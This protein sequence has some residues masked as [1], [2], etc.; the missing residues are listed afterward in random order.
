MTA[1]GFLFASIGIVAV[2]AGIGLSNPAVL[3]IGAP[4]LVLLAV[5]LA[6]QRTAAVTLS[7]GDT[8]RAIE[9][10]AMVLTIEIASTGPIGRAQLDLNLPPGLFA[11]DTIEVSVDRATT[12]EVP[13]Q[14]LR[15]GIY[16]L[17]GITLFAAGTAGVTYQRTRIADPPVLKVFPSEATARRLLEPIETQLAYGDL[18][19]RERGQG[20][21]YADL[22]E[23]HDGDDRRHINWRASA[24][25]QT[26]WVN[27]RHPERN[28][29]VVLFIDTFHDARR[30]VEATL[31]FAVRAVA[32]LAKRHLSR[33][34][35]VG[36]VT[37]GEPVRWLRPG[38]G[39]RQRYRILDTLM[40]SRQSRHIYWRG[41]SALPRQ[42]LPTKALI[43]AVTPLLDDRII[44]AIADLH[45]RGLDVGVVEIPAEA[46][47]EEPG[48][49]TDALA[50]R[51]WELERD[52]VRR[53]F[54]RAGVAITVW[55]PDEP[56]ERALM[57]VEQFRR[58]VT[59][60]RV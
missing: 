57:E 10:D 55:D 12:Q 50:R 33:H 36:L 28:S 32:G 37:F 4:F 40:A 18:V 15:W 21:E 14:C 3:A 19:A 16:D 34:D 38:A 53:R 24:R 6:G 2:A 42:A 52:T 8:I 59:R 7:A 26:M 35:R 51:I 23:M 13:V 25:S 44:A 43:V 9:G 27:D 39:A 1:R 5:G 58:H 31:D 17:G 30:G 56:F 49:E 11:A 41:I 47:L 29:D 45:G 48:T 22:R 46:L 54:A 20:I 60:T